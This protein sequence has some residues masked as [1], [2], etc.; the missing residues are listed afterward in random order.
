MGLRAALAAVLHGAAFS[1][2]LW[3][4]KLGRSVRD[5][6]FRRGATGA[7][8]TA[9]SR[10]PHSVRECMRSWL[11]GGCTCQHPVASASHG[12]TSTS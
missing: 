2:V 12:R 6:L 5:D 10:V 7:T 8:Q 3:G 4:L 9:P 11:R 1:A